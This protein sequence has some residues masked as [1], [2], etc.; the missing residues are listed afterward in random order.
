MLGGDG[1]DGAARGCA[2]LVELGR[3]G[4]RAGCRSVD[5]AAM[6]GKAAAAAPALRLA[7]AA[8][9]EGGIGH[10]DSD[11]TLTAVAGFCRDLR[12]LGAQIAALPGSQDGLPAQRRRQWVLRCR[13]P[14]S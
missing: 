9:Y 3:P 7:G 13:R 10:D 5:E 4:G 11:A 1:A 2:V 6:V 8:G 14:R 12:R